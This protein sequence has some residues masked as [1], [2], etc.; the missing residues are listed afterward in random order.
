M[1]LGLFYLIHLKQFLTT[2]VLS[3]RIR[4]TLQILLQGIILKSLKMPMAKLCL[5]SRMAPRRVAHPIKGGGIGI[6]TFLIYL[7]AQLT[8]A[9]QSPS[10]RGAS[11]RGSPVK[12]INMKLITGSPHLLRGFAKTEVQ[13]YLFV[14]KSFIQK[15]CRYLWGGGGGWNA[16]HKKVNEFL[17]FKNKF[18][19]YT[20]KGSL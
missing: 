9:Y 1:K 19:S 6:Y 2:K 20:K 5:S 15:M 4:D 16:Y 14:H 3:F 12:L 11:R 17:K 8:L 13:L 10:L 7:V 18:L